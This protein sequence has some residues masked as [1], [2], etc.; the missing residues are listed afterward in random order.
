MNNSIRQDIKALKFLAI[1]I[2]AMAAVDISYQVL[3]NDCAPKINLC[4]N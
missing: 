1:L 2:V 4:S 3:A